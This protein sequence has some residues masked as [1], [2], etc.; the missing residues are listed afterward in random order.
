MG[1]V[2]E[3]VS[4][5]FGSF[6]AVDNVSLE[7]ESG[8]LVALLG[9][10]GSGKSTLLRLI[11]GLELPDTGRI[12]LTGKD[13]TYQ[14]VQERN[15]GFVFQHY[16]LF[17]HLTVR[18]NIAF[19][20]EIRKAPKN[21][22]KN[23]VSELLELVQLSG[24]GDRYPSQL[25]GGQRQRVALARALAVEPEVL[26]LD[27]PFGALDAKVRKDLRAWLRRLHDEVHVT[28][29]FVTHDQEEAMEVSDEVVVMNKGAVEQ[30]GTPAEIYDHPASAFVMSFIG[31]VNVLPSTSGLFQSNGFDS[32]HPKMFLRPQDIIIE[33]NPNGTTV[34]A[35]ISRLINLGWEIQAE[36]TLEDGQVMTAHLSRERFDELNLEP[37]QKVYVKPKDAKSF[38]LYYSI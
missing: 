15:I 9:P 23:R 3:S 5:Q 10:S 20:L 2:V 33:T 27:E 19:G 26:L 14:S 34:P 12:L 22:V 13:A 21:K 1:I 36:L 38:P 6:K 24:L 11:S 16:A 35:R 32:A 28:T 4:K 18:Q 25:S 8:S 29:V 37:Q 31:P 17:K 7:I 30:I